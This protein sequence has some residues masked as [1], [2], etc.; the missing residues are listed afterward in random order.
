MPKE[1]TLPSDYTGT[2]EQENDIVGAINRNFIEIEKEIQSLS[3]D[4]MFF[5]RHIIDFEEYEIDLY[6]SDN[7]KK[8]NVR[9]DDEFIIIT[10]GDKQI[11]IDRDG[12]VV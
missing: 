9:V 11:R 10:I 5:D 1:I 7:K 2:L 12:N 4:V 8:A 3:D 6:F